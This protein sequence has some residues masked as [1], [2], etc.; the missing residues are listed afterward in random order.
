MH[1]CNWCGIPCN[2][3]Y[4]QACEMNC[5]KECRRCHKPYPSLHYFP[6]VN[7]AHCHTCSR[8]LEKAKY[9][10]Q[11]MR[12]LLLHNKNV[13]CKMAKRL[14]PRLTAEVLD[15]VKN[16]DSYNEPPLPPAPEEEEEEILPLV[17]EEEELPKKRKRK[18]S[19]PAKKRMKHDDDDDDHWLH[20]QQQKKP[21]GKVAVARKKTSRP[22]PKNKPTQLDLYYINVLER[23][24][25]IVEELSG[26]HNY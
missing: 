15:F 26:C 10:T 4:C 3:Y 5:V 8:H 19:S 25:D 17:E 11:S 2:Y 7:I 20:Q 24:L 21:V 9:N 14:G 16:M 22:G 1:A 13:S 6:D 23:M 18:Q 12:N